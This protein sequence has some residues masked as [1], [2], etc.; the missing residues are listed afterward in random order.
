MYNCN[1]KTI[2][3]QYTSIQDLISLAGTLIDTDNV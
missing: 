1:G 2:S 3:L